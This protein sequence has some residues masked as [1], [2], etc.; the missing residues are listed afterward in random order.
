MS[1][2]ATGTYNVYYSYPFTINAANYGG[3]YIIGNQAT[4]NRSPLYVLASNNAINYDAVFAQTP[5]Q[6]NAC[7]DFTN[8]LNDA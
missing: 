2:D 3:T 8:V 1:P 6:V 5:Q 7:T 4:M